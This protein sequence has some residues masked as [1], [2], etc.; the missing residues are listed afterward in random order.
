MAGEL[1]VDF[2]TTGLNIYFQLRN[3]VGQI[4]NGSMF[5]TYATANI[6]TYNINA[7]EQGT[8]SRLYVATMPTSTAGSY[9]II[10]KVRSGGSPAETDVT[11]AEG[12][13]EWSGTV[14]VSLSSVQ[15]GDYEDGAVWIDT[16]NGTA[17]T[18]PYV[19][20]TKHKPVSTLADALTI[21]TDSTVNLRKFELV[22][23]LLTLASSYTAWK[24]SGAG[25]G[26]VVATGIANSNW[27]SV[28]LGSQTLISTYFSNLFIT[29]ICASAVNNSTE[30]FRC[31]LRDCSLDASLVIECG[32]V[33]TITVLR[34]TTYRFE[35]CYDSNSVSAPVINFAAVGSSELYLTD[36]N[37][38]IELQNMGVS[39]TDTAVITGQGKLTLNANCTGGTI[40]LHGIWDIVDNSGL[41]TITGDWDVPGDMTIHGENVDRY[42]AKVWLIDDNG[43]STDRYMVVWHF[44]GQPV[45]TGITLPTIQ[46]FDSGGVDLIASTAMTQIG[47]TGTYKYNASGAERVTSGAI[48]MIKVTATI[49]GSVRTWY[50][51]I[52]RDSSA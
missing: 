20:G 15:T 42:Q 11:I 4:W 35:R 38:R 36:Y 41:V 33:N 5:E 34:A 28:N 13:I 37:G 49:D 14:V 30:F 21:A 31:V 43:A 8:A 50:Q 1:Q 48:Y 18:T 47:S 2:G 32:L 51:P 45:T 24:F 52:G 29:G 46:V 7:T 44:A 17:G 39:G 16:V 10:A 19:N 12:E 27:Q 23:G 40:E 25:G 9:N 22:S 6:A 26:D 3:S